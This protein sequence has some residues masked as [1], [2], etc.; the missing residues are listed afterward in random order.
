VPS[1]RGEEISRRSTIWCSKPR[2]SPPPGQRDH[3]ARPERQLLRARHHPSTPLFA[4]LLRAVGRVEGIERI[5]YTSPH[6]KDLSPETIAAMVETPA[7]CPQLHLPLQS[8]SDRVLKAMRRSYKVDRYVDRLARARAA[9]DDL[10]VTTDLIVGFPVRATPTSTRRSRSWR[11]VS[12][13]RP[14]PSS[15]RRAKERG[16]R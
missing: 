2:C 14:T 6:P 7:V 13:I 10:A 16:A 5:R 15:S 4:D 11:P 9:I 12:S 1:V 3:V 8:G